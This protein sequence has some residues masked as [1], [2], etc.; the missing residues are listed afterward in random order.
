MS[1]SPACWDVMDEDTR[2]LVVKMAAHRLLAGLMAGRPALEACDQASAVLAD[3]FCAALA[4]AGIRGDA[5]SSA[6]RHFT[7]LLQQATS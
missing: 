7:R 5:A 1:A 2:D 6:Q 3:S 4:A